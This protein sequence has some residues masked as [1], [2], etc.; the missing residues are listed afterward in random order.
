MV[1]FLKR[2]GMLILEEVTK[3]QYLPHDKNLRVK[4]EA[5]KIV[6]GT[7]PYVGISVEDAMKMIV[8]E[9]EY[10]YE[11]S[12]SEKYLQCALLH[13]QAYL[14]MGFN[15]NEDFNKILNVLGIERDDIFPKKFYTEKIK[16]NKSQVRS[17]LGKWKPGNTMKI[18]EVVEDIINRVKFQREGI[19]YYKNDGTK[20][21]LQNMDSEIEVYELVINKKET[22]FHD[23]KRKKYFTFKN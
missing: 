15:Y 6:L 20:K 22:Y 4:I 13:I 19:V 23:I 16:L 1:L 11:I 9:F 3:V 5:I 10:F 2:I 12:N 7:L 18:G 21:D 14:E 17:M 8:S